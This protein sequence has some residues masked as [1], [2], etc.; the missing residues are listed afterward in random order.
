M[1]KTAREQNRMAMYALVEEYK[2]SNLHQK[3]F[4]EQK[5]ISFDRFQYW[6]Q[7]YKESQAE[8]GF[9]PVKIFSGKQKAPAASLE[10]QY[11]NGV[12]LRLP[13]GTSLNFIRSLMTGI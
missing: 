1:D 3:P 7:R 8:H 4:C 12:I 13:S 10:I 5:G 9:V 6:Y 2:T 11:P